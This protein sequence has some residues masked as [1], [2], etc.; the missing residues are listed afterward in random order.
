MD[1]AELHLE[2]SGAGQL[3]KHPRLPGLTVEV[4]MTGLRSYSVAIEWPPR[5]PRI[6]FEASEVPETWTNV[7]HEA[8]TL[9][10]E[11]RRTGP[12]RIT[13]R[14]LEPHG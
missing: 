4:S 7:R 9:P 12:T 6:F 2:W 3:A 5:V 14:W 13:C 11:L 1:P 8:I 10:L